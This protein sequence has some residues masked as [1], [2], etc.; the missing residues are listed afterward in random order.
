MLNLFFK[1]QKTDGK[2]ILSPVTGKCVDLS[3]VPDP[4]FANKIMGEGV[5]FIF[6]ED[7]I[8]SPCNGNIEAIASTNHA[9]GFIC[10][11]GLELLLHVGVDTVKLG[12]KGFTPLVSKDQKVH[13][14]TPLLKI[15]REFME[16]N[17][18]NLITS[19]VVTN[20]LSFNIEI[21]GIDTFVEKAKSEIIRVNI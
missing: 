18:V 1:K 3:N 4:M 12:G 21:V 10:E 20:H 15:D 2:R 13:I 16:E 6:E 19:M 11:N 5:A 17:G 8:Y 7:T 9:F 14:G